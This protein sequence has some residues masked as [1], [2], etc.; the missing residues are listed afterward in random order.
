MFY[1]YNLQLGD[2]PLDDTFLNWVCFNWS[3]KLKGFWPVSP[4]SKGG[5]GGGGGGALFEIGGTPS[6]R[7]T[8]GVGGVA[9]TDAVND[10][11]VAVSVETEFWITFVTT[12]GFDKDPLICN[13][14]I[15]T[16]L[17]LLYPLEPFV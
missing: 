6:A 7:G 4:L 15:L 5:G 10:K 13:R 14:F 9:E 11:F 1:N 12:C 16:T 17:W 8:E 2:E 3:A